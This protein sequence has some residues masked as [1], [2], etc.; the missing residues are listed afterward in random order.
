MLRFGLVSCLTFLSILSTAGLPSSARA[1]DAKPSGKLRVYLGTYTGPHSK[2]IYVCE[3]DLSDG[4][5]SEP[6]VAAEAKN[7]SFLALHPDGKHLYAVSEVDGTGAVLAFAIDG[8]TGTLKAINHQPAGGG[9]PC[10]LT[11]D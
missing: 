8:E 5:L 7:P 9:G 10:H 1:E 3:L 6:R 4:S 2:G 11:D